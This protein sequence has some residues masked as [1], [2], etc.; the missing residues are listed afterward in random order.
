M[1]SL[2]SQ[3]PFYKLSVSVP[4]MPA[5]CCQRTE[6]CQNLLTCVLDSGA[7]N[8]SQGSS[9]SLLHQLSSPCLSGFSVCKLPHNQKNETEQNKTYITSSSSLP[10]FPHTRMPLPLLS[11]SHP[12]LPTSGLLP[13]SN[14]AVRIDTEPQQQHCCADVAVTLNLNC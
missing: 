6:V 7:L 10:Q 11:P 2:N 9:W 8:P 3:L 14:G 1:K 5:H 12:P 13:L 4:P